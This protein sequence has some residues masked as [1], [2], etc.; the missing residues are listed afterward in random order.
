MISL[1]LFKQKRRREPCR[2]EKGHLFLKKL[3]RLEKGHLFLKK[4]CRL[5]KGHTQ[6]VVSILEFCVNPIRTG[7]ILDRKTGRI[8]E[9]DFFIR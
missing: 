6:D 8:K 7:H 5:E 9:G 3:C 2:L 1:I 4:L